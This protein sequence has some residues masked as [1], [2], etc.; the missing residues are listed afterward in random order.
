MIKLRF[1]RKL[2]VIA[3][4]ISLIAGTFPGV[5][6]AAESHLQAINPSSYL[7]ANESVETYISPQINTESSRKIN[8]IVQLEGQPVSVGTY[9][10]KIGNRSLAASATARHVDQEQNEFIDE[11][12]DTGIDFDINYQYNTVLNGL[13]VTIPA[14]KIPLLAELPGV[15]SI[16]EN[17]IWHA[18]PIQPSA[19]DANT[20]YDINPIEQISADYAWMKGLTG[21]GLKVGVID[22]GIDYNHPDIAPAYV[23]GYDSFNQDDDPYED[24]PLTPAEDPYGIGYM[25]SF[26]GTHVAGTIVGR[27][28]NTEGDFAHKGV[29]YEAELY[30]Y[31]VL[32]RVNN[33][34]QESGSTA[35]VI[36]GIERA[37]KDGMD[38]I[39]LSLS[40]DSDKDVNSP[41]VIAVNNAILS[42]VITVVSSGNFGPGSFTLG[43]PAIS[44]LAI[45][46]GAVDSPSHFY[47]SSVS[48]ELTNGYSVTAATYGPLD[49]YAAAWKPGQTDFQTI[50]G[51]D[52]IE[53]VYSGLGTPL[54][55][56]SKNV[57]DK[58]VLISNGGISFLE[59]VYYAN[60]FGAKA[61]LL[62]NGAG[63]N[64]QID[65]NESITGRDGFL[66]VFLDDSDSY[67]N[68]FVIEGN[69]GRELARA[70]AEN[71][72]QVLKATFNDLYEAH[73]FPGDVLASFSAWGPNFDNNLSIKPDL[74]APG[75]NIRSTFPAYRA[76]FEAASYATAYQRLNGTS[77]ATPHIAGLAL[78]LKQNNPNL[79]P[80][81]IRSALTNTADIL[82]DPDNGGIYD[83]YQ[84]GSGRASVEAALTTPALLQAVEP[85]TILDINY[86]R[87][88]V[89]NYNSSA[90]FGVISPGSYPVKNLQLKNIS[91]AEVSYSAEIKWH[92]EQ[93][94]IEAN[95]SQNQLTAAAN[96]IS[97][98]QLRLH[99]N[100]NADTGIYEGQVNL[101]SPGLPALHLPFVIYVGE[102]LPDTGLGIQ[103]VYL[104]NSL[105]YPNRNTQNTTDISY[106]LTA[107]DTNFIAHEI[108]DLAGKHLGFFTRELTGTSGTYFQPG[109]YKQTGIDGDYLATDEYGNTLYDERGF[110]VLRS[111]E[112]GVYQIHIIASQLTDPRD[113]TSFA[114][115]SDGSKIIYSAT[116]LLRV[117]NS[118]QPIGG[119]DNGN[120]D[121]TSGGG[122]GG[123]AASPAAAPAPKAAAVSAAAQSVIDP[124]SKNIAV[125]A[126]TVIE[127][128]V[129]KATITDHMLASPIVS[130]G[131]SPATIIINAPSAEETYVNFTLTPKQIGLLKGL[132]STST[133][134]FSVGGSAVAL[135]VALF[136]Q[137]P[138]EANLEVIVSANDKYKAA[139]SSYSAGGAILGT[140]VQIEANWVS[141]SETKPL[142][143][144]NH[145]FIKRAF[146]VPG[147]IP[148]NTAGVLYEA[149]GKVSPIASSFKA[150]KDQSTIVT[151]SRPGFSIYAAVSRNTSFNDISES[152]AAAH[153]TALA[154]KFIIEGTGAGAFSPNNHL[155]RAEFTAL[156]V[157][158]LGLPSSSTAN[159]TD[160]HASDWFAEDIAAAYQAGLIQGTGNHKFAPHANVTRQELAVI[161]DRALKLT[162]SKLQATSSSISFADD[163][164]IASYAK[165]SVS[166]LASAGVIGGETGEAGTY[167]NPN[168]AT[169][170][171]TAASALYL[172]LQAAELID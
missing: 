36:D 116:T 73:P 95:L 38:V 121:H 151:V 56:M 100:S 90:S 19:V 39:N 153:I 12:I 70:I 20:G 148:S 77:M 136:A 67:T 85:I 143:I 170:R 23:D 98:F 82:E 78:L 13:E 43:S 106:K 63:A 93:D 83:V 108:T 65:L 24:L 125:S 91:S 88:D 119:G 112:D 122:G 131:N 146:T 55:L 59:K 28:V 155:T 68:T 109:L 17:S 105:I 31:K 144:P 41:M 140:P 52:A 115:R 53:V 51:T 89:I 111:L 81:D 54:E 26:H 120:D 102:E 35:Q 157:R 27:G 139:F 14:N 159:F 154:N 117:N 96:S 163:N 5:G 114:K 123:I 167:F 164:Q 80:F 118:S 15:K 149:N 8:V 99:V 1:I 40:S 107:A 171:A 75:V 10:S 158:A 138:N 66:D 50:M 45:S 16:H 134:V 169:T 64:G 150:Q 168:K 2:P 113:L 11:A 110:E 58:V 21:K 71:P 57:K 33:N 166:L 84:Q 135:P 6:L 147:H 47:S 103:E 72:G 101:T 4:A 161:L 87:K 9:A 18:A 7:N 94:S 79:S 142:Q 156:L 25:G 42:G 165:D 128:G 86:N 46:V 22:S 74:V 37:V 127:D 92:D 160:V 44:P 162:G 62:F 61:V 97:E 172:L 48:A 104:T 132:E 145:V 76:K 29:A 129:T 60:M 69:K 141:E 137:A 49:F 34:P 152:T 3:L 32:G 133:I 124:T 126:M 130:A 30:A